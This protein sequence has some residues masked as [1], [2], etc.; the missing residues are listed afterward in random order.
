MS[1][2]G[3]GGGVYDPANR[4]IERKILECL[5]NLG[6][7]SYTC[8]SQ[9]HIKN[10]FIPERKTEVLPTRDITVRLESP[11]AAYI[12]TYNT[13]DNTHTVTNPPENFGLTDEILQT[14]LNCI[15]SNQRGGKKRRYKNRTRRVKR[16]YSHK[17]R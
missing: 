1:P 11:G 9:N 12:V 14:V 7:F 6:N 16:K 13:A 5:N 10:T 3:A 17:R 4:A 2:I 8:L 15:R